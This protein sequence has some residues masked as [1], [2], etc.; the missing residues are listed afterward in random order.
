MSST[1]N[2]SLS[3]GYINHW[4]VAGPL[5]IELHEGAPDSARADI[6]QRFYE[7]DSG[8]NLP[9][10]DVGSLGSLTEQHPLIK[11]RYYGCLTYRMEIIPF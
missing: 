5:K 11:W 1:L 4:L 10:V 9:P 8:I 6:F 2:Y 3:N 7:P